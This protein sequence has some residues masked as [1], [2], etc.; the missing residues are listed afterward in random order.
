[1]NVEDGRPQHAASHP[2]LSLPTSSACWTSF[3]FLLLP[4]SLSLS[5]CRTSGPSSHRLIG[6]G[7]CSSRAAGMAGRQPGTRTNQ[8]EIYVKTPRDAV[9]G[10]CGG[11]ERGA[12]K[13]CHL[14]NCKETKLMLGA[15]Y[16]FGCLCPACI[17]I[18]QSICWPI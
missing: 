1:M 15:D 8:A 5:L 17:L 13:G 6:K 2:S 18:L 14:K 4:F 10:F 7:T 16:L 12:A 3:Q 9:V 11:M